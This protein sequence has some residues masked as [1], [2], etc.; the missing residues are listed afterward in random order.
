MKQYG[1][2]L[3]SNGKDIG[4]LKRVSL[5]EIWKNEAKDFTQWLEEN[6]DTLSEV[7]E[8]SLSA[9]EREKKTGSFS[10]DL[11]AEDDEGRPVII[12]N[13]L[14][15]TDHEH[16]GKILT[17][18][19]NI[20]ARGAIWISSQPR[21]EH[22]K[23][24]S[25]LNEST[26]ADFYL[27]NVEA[28]RI[29]DSPPAPLFRVIAG[30]TEEGKKIG[31]KKKEFAER[32][33]IRERFWGQLLA[34]AKNKTRLHSNISASKYNWIGTSAGVRGLNFQY[35]IGKDKANVELYID[36]G[37]KEENKAIFDQLFK[38]NEEIESSFGEGL[39]WERLESKR[40]CRITKR[41]DFAGY[42]DEEM[43]DQLQDMMIDSMIQL[44]KALRP[45]IKKIRS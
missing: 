28:V 34:K 7:L 44:E 15:K 2:G 9:V 31:Q 33:F 27:V 26:P 20:E 1:R 5:R 45:F 43:W 41:F 38:H 19:S 30:P 37:E 11:L 40:A 36:K 17:Y 21:P 23:A 42:K 10:A 3:I 22:T 25:W 6:L 35:G 12:E 24:I 16:L 39:S 29:G 14:E 4:K 32:Y 13:Q 8:F 18:L